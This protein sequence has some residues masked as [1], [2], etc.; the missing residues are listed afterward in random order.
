MC[1]ASNILG[2]M[3]QVITLIKGSKPAVP[4]TSIHGA[5]H[6]SIKIDIEGPQNDELDILGYRVQYLRRQELNKGWDSA[7]MVEFDKGKSLC[8]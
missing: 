8:F 5:R 2:K 1:K 4:Q 6:D 3:E 7:Q